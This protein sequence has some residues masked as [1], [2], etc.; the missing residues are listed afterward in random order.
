M[1]GFFIMTDNGQKYSEIDFVLY[2]VHG[3]G[4]NIYPQPVQWQDLTRGH[5]QCRATLAYWN[6][7]RKLVE[8]G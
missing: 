2:P 4:V 3:A 8:A 7:K 5:V 6:L 1:V